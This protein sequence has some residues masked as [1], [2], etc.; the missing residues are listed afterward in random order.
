[1]DNQLNNQ[2]REFKKVLEGIS[3]DINTSDVWHDIKDRLPLEKKK[4][5]KPFWL[6]SLGLLGLVFLSATAMYTILQEEDNVSPTELVAFKKVDTSTSKSSVVSNTRKSNSNMAHESNPIVSE[7]QIGDS[8]TTDTKAYS[9]TSNIITPSI[10]V[11]N[12]SSTNRNKSLIG[13]SLTRINPLKSYRSMAIESKE[14][15][16]NNSVQLSEISNVDDVASLGSM[17]SYIVDGAEVPVLSLAF[18]NSIE[19]VLINASKYKFFGSL[20][21]GTNFGL[22]ENSIIDIN[23][24]FDGSK[25]NNESSRFG[26][27]NELVLGIETSK[28]W[29]FFAGVSHTNEVYNYSNQSIEL[30][31]LSDIGVQSIHI[32]AQGFENEISGPVSVTRT[33]SYD[34][35]VHRRHQSIGLNLGVAKR[36][37]LLKRLSIIPEVSLQYNLK[38]STSGYYFSA[39]S[40]DVDIIASTQSNPYTSDQFI[41]YRAGLGVDYDLGNF[42][43]GILGTYIYNPNNYLKEPTFYQSK[44]DLLSLQFSV[45]YYPNW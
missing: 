5:R 43:I 28:A 15:L 17:L 32:D 7:K 31:Q 42:S 2:E 14:N 9:P 22:A 8:N 18:D 27:S 24:E 40:G 30:T 26:I 33:T 4:E 36:V 21:S 44:S 6:F 38:Q 23:S 34:K 29:R 1:M 20:R 37:S 12:T 11:D 45:S 3:F 35:S 13:Q 39:D 41:R 16:L 19:P 10:I 25:F